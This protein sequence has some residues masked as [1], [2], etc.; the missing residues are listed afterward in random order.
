MEVCHNSGDVNDNT[1]KNVRYDTRSGNMRERTK[2]GTYGLPVVRLSDGKAFSSIAEA[3]R[4]SSS[5]H[6]AIKKHCNRQVR[7]PKWRW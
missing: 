2:H 5:K 3:L 7:N 6:V 4:A 1:V